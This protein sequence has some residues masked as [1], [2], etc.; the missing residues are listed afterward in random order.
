MVTKIY[1]RNFSAICD[2]QDEETIDY[3]LLDNINNTNNLYGIEVV[4]IM[5]GN[6]YKESIVNLS[7]S[8]DKVM[9]AL[10]YLYE[11]SVKIESI[12]DIISDI[13]SKQLF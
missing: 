4:S 7:R 5:S 1:S 9:N 10:K 8:K 11:N 2:L 12:R 13:F 6:I 3:N